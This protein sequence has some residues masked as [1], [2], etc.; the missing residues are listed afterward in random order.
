MN[1]CCSGG[2]SLFVV[3]AIDGQIER[4]AKG[5]VVC[6]AATAAVEPL[7][8]WNGTSRSSGGGLIVPSAASWEM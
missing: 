3:F 4:T 8:V 1:H 5:H 7:T 2:R 6:A